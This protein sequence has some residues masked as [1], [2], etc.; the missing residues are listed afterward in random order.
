MD[1]DYTYFKGSLGRSNDTVFSGCHH[2]NAQYLLTS[3]NVHI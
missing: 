3:V 2:E 1:N